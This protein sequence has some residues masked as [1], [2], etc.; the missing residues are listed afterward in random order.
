[1]KS[2]VFHFLK[3]PLVHFLLMGV[4]LFFVY[5]LIIDDVSF[6]DTNSIVVDQDR[7]LHFMQYRAKTFDNQRFKQLLNDLPPN[8]LQVL[9]DDYVREEVMFREAKILELDR[10]DTVARQRLIQQMRYL[11]RSFITTEETLTDS[12]L[13]VYL[14]EHSERYR[15]PDTITFT[16]VFFSTATQTPKAARMQAATKLRQLNQHRVPFHE[17]TLH[18]DRFLYHRNYINK[19]TDSIASHFGLFMQ[20]AI[21]ALDADSSVWRGPYQSP[22][23]YHL[24]LITQKIPAYIP[25]VAEIRQRLVQDVQQEREQQQLKQA[26]D[27]MVEDYEV[28]VQDSLFASVKRQDNLCCALP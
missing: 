5:D 24:V 17:A 16:H 21:F 19:D 25:V 1:M 12:K 4:C 22:Y 27:T 10:Y 9:I 8:K 2:V 23:G 7:L 18:G 11:I 26:I 3:E 14:A 6:S 15:K 20:Q 13:E 28:T